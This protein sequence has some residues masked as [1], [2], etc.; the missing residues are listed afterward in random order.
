MNI[1][2][3]IYYIIIE[4]TSSKYLIFNIIIIINNRYLVYPSPLPPQRYTPQ[5]IRP[6]P[7]SLSYLPQPYPIMIYPRQP[8]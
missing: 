3:Y 8:I 6:S 4:K 1:S 7:T 5:P 2:F